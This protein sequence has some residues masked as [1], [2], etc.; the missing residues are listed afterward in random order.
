METRLVFTALI[1][2]TH[3]AWAGNPNCQAAHDY[4]LTRLTHVV[5][6]QF[7]ARGNPLT[8]RIKGNLGEF[9]AFWVGRNGPHSSWSHAFT[10]TCHQP[11][12]DI[13]LAG[14]DIVWVCFNDQDPSR[15]FVVLQEIK[16]T[17]GAS[18][19]YADKLA[20]DYEKLFG[21]ELS[22]TLQSR[23]Q[24]IKNRLELEHNRLD[25]C[26]R[27]NA[28]AGQAPTDSTGV[29]LLP[30]LV[31]DVAS[32]SEQAAVKLAAVRSAVLQL[33]WPQNQVSQ[34]SIALSDLDDRLTRLSWGDH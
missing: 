28:V 3:T 17:S 23:L 8:T 25:L 27:L 34:W 9:T 20:E 32:S 12:M 13:S 29:R 1:Q 11:L 33:G 21:L 15:D 24:G 18:L 5:G 10:L 26:L 7:R 16:T 30:T 19:N 14:V 6:G 31:H 2:G 22:F 4:L